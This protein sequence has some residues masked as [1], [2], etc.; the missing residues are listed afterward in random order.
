MAIVGALA[1]VDASVLAESIAEIEKIGGVTTSSLD[2]PDRI[3]L[4]IE[5][6]SVDNAHRLMTEQIAAVRGVLG[7]WPVF[8]STED[9]TNEST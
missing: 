2:D 4:T 6:D 9:E 5:K 1:R 7:A 8:A 3:G